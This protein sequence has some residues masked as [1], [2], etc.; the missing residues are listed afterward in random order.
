[1]RV[2]P[3]TRGPVEPVSPAPSEERAPPHHPPGG[4]GRVRA[5]KG[6]MSAP[7]GGARAPPRRGA[8]G[9]DLVATHK[10]LN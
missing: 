8:P 10:S 9:G 5:P 7:Q 2:R 3:G 4:G 6:R 1:M